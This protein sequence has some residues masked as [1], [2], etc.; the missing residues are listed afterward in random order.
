MNVNVSEIIA[1]INL[2]S[3]NVENHPSGIMKPQNA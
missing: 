1:T 2:G 3:N